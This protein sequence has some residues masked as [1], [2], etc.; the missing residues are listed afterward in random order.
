MEYDAFAIGARAFQIRENKNMKQS[1]LSQV[2]GIHQATYSKFE[3][4]RYDMPTSKLIKLSDYLGVPVS[5]LVG[6]KSIPH[7]TDRECLEVENYKKFL[8]S[9]RKK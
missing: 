7:L 2:L 8:I 9:K 1:E 3:N 5:W 6:E 4:G